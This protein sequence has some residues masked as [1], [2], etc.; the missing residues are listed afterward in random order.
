MSAEITMPQLSDTM[1]EGVLVKWLKKEGDKISS[2][3]KIAQVE[4]DKAVMEMESFDAGVV[5]ALVVAEGQKVAVGAL[6]AV[7]ATGSEN[8]AEVKK[9]IGSRPSA[10]ASPA[11]AAP[12]VASGPSSREEVAAS[13]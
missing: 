9:K 7:I 13:R 10:A 1:T 5:A 11:V 6:M 3:E 2:G 4:T 8:P 12:V